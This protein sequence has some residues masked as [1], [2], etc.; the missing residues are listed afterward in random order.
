MAGGGIK[1]NWG[2]VYKMID[3][4][5]TMAAK[6]LR[7]HR[8]G[9]TGDSIVH[10]V[11]SICDKKTFAPFY[12]HGWWKQNGSSEF[13]FVNKTSSI[14]DVP[15]TDADAARN[16]STGIS[17]RYTWRCDYAGSFND[18]AKILK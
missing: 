7:L 11:K 4:Q 10:K 6:Q 9:K 3:L 8:S 17:N 14:N 13:D 5:I 16:S 1:L 18:R 2:L 12:Q 15:F